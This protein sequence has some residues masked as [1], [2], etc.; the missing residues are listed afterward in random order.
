[1]FSYL[2][3]EGRVHSYKELKLHELRQAGV[4]LLICD[5]D[6]TLAVHD[7]QGVSQEIKAFVQSVKEAGLMFCLISNNRHKRAEAFAK[8]LHV[9]AYSF[10]LKPLRH[11]YFKVLREHGVTASQV[12]CLGDQL[13]TD[14]LG[15]K[16]M[17]MK[18]VLCDP[19]SEKDIIYTR[20]SRWLERWVLQRIEKR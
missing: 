16:R 11:T 6:N 20:F 13:F 18:V 1:M 17:D 12:L 19:L 14:V 15:A 4:R 8:E 9:R 3:P 5:L 2:K 7:E 10:A